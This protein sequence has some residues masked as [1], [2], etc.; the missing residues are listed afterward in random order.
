M[1]LPRSFFVPIQFYALGKVSY[2]TKLP[3]LDPLQ[4]SVTAEVYIHV[5]YKNG[6]VYMKRIISFCFYFPK[7]CIYFFRTIEKWAVSSLASNV[8][9]AKL[10]STANDKN[11]S[12]V[13]Y[14]LLLDK[15]SCQVCFKLFL[16]KVQYIFSGQIEGQFRRRHFLEIFFCQKQL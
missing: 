10:N 5:E 2:L 12:V 15:N 1:G 4:P 11:I 13:E 7:I 14:K 16:R 8:K 3:S 9:Q 6:M